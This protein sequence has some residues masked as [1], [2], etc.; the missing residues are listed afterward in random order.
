ML[1]RALPQSQSIYPGITPFSSSKPVHYT[2]GLHTRCDNISGRCSP[3]PVYEDC[4][5]PNRKFCSLW[6]T[7][8][9]LMSVAVVLELAGLV[10][11]AIVLLGGKQKRDAG[12]KMITII[13]GFCTICQLISMGIVAG[14]HQNDDHFFTGW[15]LAKSWILCT[16]SWCLQLAT[17]V[18]MIGSTY[19]LPDEGGYE[20]IPD[21]ERMN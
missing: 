13:L 21:G 6:R 7:T 3:F 2:Y 10:G 9:F 8:G 15:Y 5:G 12:W 11:F 4:R 18:G 20:L 14:L 16:V 1:I 19:L 17:I